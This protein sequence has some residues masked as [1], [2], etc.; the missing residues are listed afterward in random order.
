MRNVPLF[1]LASLSLLVGQIA[2]QQGQVIGRLSFT[3]PAGNSVWTPP[4]VAEDTFSGRIESLDFDSL[5]NMA[6]ITLNTEALPVLGRHYLE[7]CDGPQAGFVVD[8]V[9]ASASSVTVSVDPSTI[10]LVVG[11]K[12]IVREHLTVGGLLPEGANFVPYHDTLTVFNLDG[13]RLDIFWDSLVS[14]WS[15]PFGNNWDD[16]VLLPGQGVLVFLSQALEI[17]LGKNAVFT[18]VK[19]TP[20]RLAVSVEAVNLL[21]PVNPFPGDYNI[22]EIG[23]L[24]DFTEFVDTVAFHSTDG[25]FRLKDVL[26]T[27]GGAFRSLFF[28]VLSDAAST[29]RVSRLEA[30]RVTPG[31][32]KTLNLTPAEVGL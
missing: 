13:S 31:Q 8:V 23:F 1:F 5:R 29:F 21:G 12:V 4:F 22:A 9:E 20:T 11:D 32:D 15:D 6:V 2:A 7:V 26:F 28:D 24:P 14:N 30:S 18:H 27:E 3:L 19:T 16:K 17:E 25:Q 10:G